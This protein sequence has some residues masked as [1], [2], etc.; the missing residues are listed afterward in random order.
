MNS[1]RIGL[2][3]AAL[4]AGFAT[5]SAQTVAA[6]SV[7]QHANGKR[8]SIGGYGEVAYSRNFYMT[9]VTD[10]A[11]PLSTRKIQAMVVSTFLM[12]SST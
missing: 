2:M 1:L 5:A 3:S 8:L 12:Q 4:V 9:V 7:M 6:D 10:K 11:L